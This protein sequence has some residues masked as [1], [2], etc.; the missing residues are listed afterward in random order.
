VVNEW[1]LEVEWLESLKI[2]REACGSERM[3]LLYRQV[4]IEWAEK[5]LLPCAR[6]IYRYNEAM[7]KCRVRVQ[8]NPALTHVTDYRV[9]RLE[10]FA[11]IA[12]ESL[13]HILSWDAPEL[14]A[15]CLKLGCANTRLLT[16][17]E[18]WRRIGMELDPRERSGDRSSS[19]VAK[20]YEDRPL[21]GWCKGPIVTLSASTTRKDLHEGCH[22]YILKV[23]KPQ[24]LR[25]R[26]LRKAQGA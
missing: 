5:D 23:V 13:A 20:L 18:R 1:N 24:I 26:E 17:R 2:V 22:D 14:A 6:I 4:D 7:H 3:L 16:P 11:Y 10:V 12:A 19:L 25:E 9:E 15:F 21:C 8:V